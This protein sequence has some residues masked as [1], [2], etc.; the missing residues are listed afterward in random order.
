MSFRLVETDGIEIFVSEKLEKAGAV[1]AFTTRVGGVSGGDYAS[2]NLRVNCEDSREN[3][4]KN[5]EI[6]ARTL[7]FSIDDVV[8]SR[9]V[10][11]KLVRRADAGEGLFRSDR[12]DADA[13]IS[14]RPLALFVFVADCVPI[15]LYDRAT[16]A[17]AAVHAG[18]RGTALDIVGAAVERM[19][20]EYGT[21]AR[22]IVA[23]IGPHICCGCFEC[24]G[25]VG[26][27]MAEEY[28]ADVARFLVKKGGKVHPDLGLINMYALARAGVSER[29]IDLCD[30]CTRCTPKLFWSHRLTGDRRGVQGAVILPGRD[31]K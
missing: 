1:H 10:H 9:Q 7:G 2:L 28:G 29:N 25:E 16:G 31:A 26:D 15:L 24:G 4:E 17:A 14:D 11:G 18:W 30:E 12:P 3:V 27:A 23:A 21:R 6:L 13:V 22:D 19:A 8:M 5:Y 20:E